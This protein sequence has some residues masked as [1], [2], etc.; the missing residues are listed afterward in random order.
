MV[1]ITTLLLLLSQAV[2]QAPAPA[3]RSTSPGEYVAG[4][5]DVLNVLVFG[6]EDLTKAVSLDADACGAVCASNRSSAVINMSSI[7]G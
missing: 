7:R 2:P 5:Q 1:L 3:P 6:E 4:P